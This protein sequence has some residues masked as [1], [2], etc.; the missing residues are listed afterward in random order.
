MI[1][2][3][4]RVESSTP[5]VITTGNW[6]W[7]SSFPRAGSR[8]KTSIVRAGRGVPP[9]RLAG[10]TSCQTPGLRYVE[11]AES[12]RLGRACPVDER[13]MTSYS[14]LENSQNM[15][16]VLYA[17]NWINSASSH[18]ITK[19]NSLDGSE[20]M[21]RCIKDN[22]IEISWD[23]PWMRAFENQSRVS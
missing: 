17:C 9:E 2:Q 19:N 1:R 6:Y 10:R 11:L 12:I 21:Y 22:G 14:T 23:Q 18:Y 15:Q 7:N 4:S 13:W 20:R 8:W 3:A 16:T 5:K